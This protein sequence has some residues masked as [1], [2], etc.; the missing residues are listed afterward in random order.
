MRSESAARA[1]AIVPVKTNI[2]KLTASRV[3]RKR[4]VAVWIRGLSLP[5]LALTRIVIPIL[6]FIF[7]CV[8]QR[9]LRTGVPLPTLSDFE[10]RE[11]LPDDIHPACSTEPHG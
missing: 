10:K 3:H 1:A 8:H 9:H 7:I 2:P 6:I 5:E 11:R 4:S